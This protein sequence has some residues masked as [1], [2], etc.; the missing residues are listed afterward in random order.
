MLATLRGELSCEARA[1]LQ[2]EI[3]KD[4]TRHTLADIETILM[5]AG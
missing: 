4:L 1:C 3:D 2:A 5:A